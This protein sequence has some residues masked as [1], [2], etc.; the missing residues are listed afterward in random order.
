VGLGPV[1]MVLVFLS[2]LLPLVFAITGITVW[3]KRRRPVA[4]SAAEPVQ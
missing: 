4:E 2:G 3:W 1:W